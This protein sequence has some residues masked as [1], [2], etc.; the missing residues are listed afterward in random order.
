MPPYGRKF[1]YVSRT[2]Q[3]W[4]SSATRESY[5]S[6]FKSQYS[7]Y[8]VKNGEN[9][10][11]ILPP[12]WENPRHFGLE[13]ALHLNVGPEDASVLCLRQMLKQRCPIC[14][15]IEKLER[16][17]NSKAASRM[18]II[19]RVLVWML[20]RDKNSDEVL[21][22]AM[23]VKVNQGIVSIAIDRRSGTVLEID[24]PD[25]GYDISF[26]REGSK[27]K[28]QYFGFKLALRPS[29]VPDSALDFIQDHPLPE[30]LNWR[31]YD[32]IL[33][34]YSDGVSRLSE[35]GDRE[36]RSREYVP[37][38][39]MERPSRTVV[40]RTSDEV[41]EEPRAPE[42]EP[43]RFREPEPQRTRVVVQEPVPEEPP[44]KLRD[45]RGAEDPA[46]PLRTRSREPRQE[47]LR[48]QEP[49]VKPTRKRV[50]AKSEP[51]PEPEQKPSAA[52]LAAA[53]RKRFEK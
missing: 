13:L 16:L 11:R 10:I 3:Q 46:P 23:P 33:A 25:E 22:W 28:T 51:A 52:S 6:I 27:E 7:S 45:R 35:E 15:E 30:I 5:P 1:V 29:S 38:E 43:Q 24:H 21:A 18:R 20:D 34:L 50:E 14:E 9:Y 49:E 4:E 47:E 48:M 37:E 36:E 40:R 53:L 17:G 19:R 31:S 42:P 2:P 12:T 26:Q 39:P 8:R 44:A 41:F 32:E